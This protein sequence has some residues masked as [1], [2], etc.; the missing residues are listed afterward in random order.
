MF[1]LYFCSDKLSPSIGDHLGPRDLD[2]SIVLY[3]GSAVE[4]DSRLLGFDL[5][6]CIEL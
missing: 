5:I 3:R 1:L 2:L 4:K 6:T